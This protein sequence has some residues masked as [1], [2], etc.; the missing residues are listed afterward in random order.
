MEQKLVL[1]MEK[2]LASAPPDREYARVSPSGSVV[3]G[4][5]D[6]TELG[7]P[8]DEL[9]GA[10]LGEPLGPDVGMP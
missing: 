7:N 5:V 2:R 10:T 6:R 9:D 1:M 8:L 3:D 4:S